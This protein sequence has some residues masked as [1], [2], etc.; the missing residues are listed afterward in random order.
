MFKYL[1]N[2][3]F[4]KLCIGCERQLLNQE[5]FL[6]LNC[7][8]ELPLTNL[9][10]IYGTMIKDIFYGTVFLEQATALF[11][12][13]KKGV[14]QKLIHQLKYKDQEEISSFLGSWLGNELKL[15]EEYKY[16]D[17]VIPVP[18][19]YKKLKARGYNQVE[20]F[21]KEIAK[22]LKTSYNDEVLSRTQH[23]TT[24][25]KKSRWLRSSSTETVF[26]INKEKSQELK[27]KHILLVDDVITTGATIKACAQEL[28]K[29][30]GVKLSLAVMAYTE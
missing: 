28:F 9:H 13:H 23:T 25:T 26:T 29:V 3:L 18:L 30:E 27:G 12:Y 17:Y 15:R 20:G 4:P 8:Q 14:V 24:Q 6:C 11:F 2:L 22:E 5:R 1:I 16:I 10:N 21:G 19:H 7:I